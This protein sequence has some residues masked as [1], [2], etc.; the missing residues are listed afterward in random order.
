[1]CQNFQEVSVAFTLSRG[2]TW[3]PLDASVLGVNTPA[4][5]GMVITLLCLLRYY[6]SCCTLNR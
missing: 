3:D 2:Y 6:R 5:Y 1:V 4:V